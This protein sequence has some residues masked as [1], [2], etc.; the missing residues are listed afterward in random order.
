MAG[1]GQSIRGSHQWEIRR[2]LQGAG[3]DRSIQDGWQFL[4]IRVNFLMLAQ[5]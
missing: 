2:L 3:L 1:V 4:V 5:E